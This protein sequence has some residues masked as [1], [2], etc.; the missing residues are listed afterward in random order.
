MSSAES[1]SSSNPVDSNSAG[2]NLNPA[3]VNLNPADVNLN[4]E[5]IKHIIDSKVNSSS[6]SAV[7]E[8]LT[9]KEMK[10]YI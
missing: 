8:D 4:R 6:V 7:V 2:V 9:K 3:G 5:I 10:N 1:H